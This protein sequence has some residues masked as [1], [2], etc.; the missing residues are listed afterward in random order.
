M[1]DTQTL[2]FKT[3]LKPLNNFFVDISDTYQRVPIDIRR[4]VALDNVFVN[5]TD[6]NVFLI[7]PYAK[8]PLTSTVT[9]TFGYSYDNRWYKDGEAID[10]EGHSAFVT[11]N[12]QFPS[13]GNLALKYN[14]FAYRPDISGDYDR[15]QGS[16][17]IQYP[18]IQNL[19]I[20]AE[21]GYAHF[22]FTDY[23][24]IDEESW[25]VGADYKL[26]AFGGTSVKAEYSTSFSESL[27]LQE[28]TWQGYVAFKISQSQY[29]VFP[30]TYEK[31]SLTVGATKIKRF[32][33]N[34]ASGQK[35]KVKVN[36]Y[37][38]VEE[39]LTI[40]R[41]DRLMGVNVN[42]SN[43]LTQKMDASLK[44]VW[45]KQKFLPEG[46][47]ARRYSAGLSVDYKAGKHI[48]TSVGYTYNARN[49]NVDTSDYHNNV[50]WVQA[51]YTF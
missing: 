24:D 45:E 40:N 49:S 29:L 5:M 11:L 33:V 34:V 31:T 23:P 21:A 12:K 8:L 25:A 32:D 22:D 14:Y 46:E 47:D 26:S 7:S 18:L 15:H 6:S 19:L 51:K 17:M 50:V 41:K 13:N 1:D 16:V 28:Q 44:G 30:V 9:T 10:S 20:W 3:Q 4:Q 27:M 38:S 37:Y 43:A 48:T 42:F 2:R 36:P 39:A 35:F